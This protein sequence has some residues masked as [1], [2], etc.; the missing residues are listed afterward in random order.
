MNEFNLQRIAAMEAAFDRTEAAVRALM[1]ALDEYET[2]K[3][4][5]DRLTDYLESG[6]W[7]EDFEM[8]E[9]GF[10]PTDLKRGV[11]S[12]DA[13]YNLLGDIVSLHEQMQE[14]CGD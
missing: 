7:R 14:I 4:D 10:V 2:V 11:L 1:Q 3:V 6:A 12:E 5:I 9:A 8:D 13:L